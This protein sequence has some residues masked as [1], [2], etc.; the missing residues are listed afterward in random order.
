MKLF[1]GPL[2]RFPVS[3]SRDTARI[4]SLA[5]ISVIDGV[6]GLLLVPDTPLGAWSTLHPNPLNS[7]TVARHPL[8][9][10]VALVVMLIVVPMPL[11]DAPH[12]IS[13][14]RFVFEPASLAQ[15][16]PPPDTVLIVALFGLLPQVRTRPSLAA[17]AL[18]NV[19]ETE[20]PDVAEQVVC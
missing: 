7:K 17:G 4:R 8:P 3:A 1:V 2:T 12:H 13:V 18:V 19:Q 9:E 11:E 10:Q 5:L 6:A 14:S 20:V 16:T 15:V